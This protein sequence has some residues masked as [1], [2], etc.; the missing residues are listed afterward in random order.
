VVVVMVVMVLSQ[1]TLGGSG[2][3]CVAFIQ[4]PSG[5]KITGSNVTQIGATTTYKI[6]ATTNITFTT[7]INK[8]KEACIY[9]IYEIINEF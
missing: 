5:Y 2:G 3:S 6:T 8:N 7:Y 4:V 1:I 9:I